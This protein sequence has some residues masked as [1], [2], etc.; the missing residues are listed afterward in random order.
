MSE[1]EITTSVD[2]QRQHFQLFVCAL[3]RL[4]I[5][6]DLLQRILTMSVFC[7]CVLNCVYVCV[8]EEIKVFNPHETRNV[9]ILYANSRYPCF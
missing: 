2:G 9:T 4:N 6:V 5:P 7:V 8:C 1:E 3:I